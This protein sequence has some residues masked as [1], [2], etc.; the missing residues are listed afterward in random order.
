[1]DREF[2]SGDRA[3]A[4]VA[5][6][7]QSN[8]KVFRHV[9]SGL[10]PAF[11]KARTVTFERTRTRAEA[12]RLQTCLRFN[13]PCHVSVRNGYGRKKIRVINTKTGMSTAPEYTMYP[14]K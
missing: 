12:R 9:V 14:P 6:A 11:P 8:I 3:Y 5:S 4:F 7:K 13:R 2:E 1:M 10:Q